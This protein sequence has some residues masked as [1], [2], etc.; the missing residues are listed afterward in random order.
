MLGKLFKH[1]MIATWKVAVSIDLA[2]IVL[3]IL[4][5][6]VL[7]ALPHVE[8]SFGM[9]LMFVSFIGLFYIGV[10]AAN[11][12]TII[13]M[14]MRYYRNLYTAEGYLTFTLPVKTDMI[15][16]SKVLTGALWM[17]LSY[18]CTFISL[19]F[20]GL[21][22]LSSIDVP[23]EEILDAVREV[24]SFLGVIDPGFMALFAMIALV[25]PFAA[26]LCMYFCVSIGQL[27]QGHKVLGT[28]L[29]V[30]GLYIF[31]QFASQIV[32]FASGFWH[33]MAQS[34][35]DID[36]SFPSI[37]KHMLLNITI[38]TVIQSIVYY[39]VCIFI[40]RKKVNLD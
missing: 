32:F 10:I 15:I 29:C 22:F 3:G 39:V 20:A 40:S 26:V 31:N 2:L 8:E 38:L 37:Y 27:W 16:H 4:T 11:I 25:T 5:G 30:I 28:V 21:G 7:H 34:A 13:Y 6:F 18:L 36:A 1:D 23:K 19:G 12:V 35:S 24:F 9:G 14:V 17:F 33:L